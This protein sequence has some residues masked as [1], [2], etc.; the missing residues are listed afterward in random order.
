M[1]NEHVTRW[2]KLSSHLYLAQSPWTS[3]LQLARNN[4]YLSASLV[5]QEQNQTHNTMASISTAATALN[6]VEVLEQ[7]LTHVSMK[8]LGR[9][10]KT[11]H[12]WNKVIY[13]S[14]PLKINLFTLLQL[15]KSLP[16]AMIRPPYSEGSSRISTS[17]NSS[18]Y[19]ST[20]SSKLSL[21]MTIRL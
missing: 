21:T 16:F 6:T 15:A 8:D 7:I 17:P 10:A 19:P 1:T 12:F 3:S 13:N 9:A 14:K 11:C 2:P 18:S 4:K 20:Q 5:L